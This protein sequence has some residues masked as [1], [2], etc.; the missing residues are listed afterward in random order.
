M[1]TCYKSLVNP[2]LFIKY[3]GVYLITYNKDLLPGD[4]KS[5][6]VTPQIFNLFLQYGAFEP[7][8]PG[9]CD[10]APQPG[11]K[12]IKT[13]NKKR[14]KTKKIKT[15]HVLKKNK[16]KTQKILHKSDIF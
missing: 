8:A 16:N 4:T 3:D 15:K 14:Y 13:K 10:D 7:A 9:E 6:P 2:N 1:S 12:K 5:V 11:G